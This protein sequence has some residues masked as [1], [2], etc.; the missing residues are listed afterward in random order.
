[1]VRGMY[2]GDLARRWPGL[3]S[4]FSGLHRCEVVSRVARSTTRKMSWGRDI[5]L[6]Q[7]H[8]WPAIIFRNE[9]FERAPRDQLGRNCADQVE[10]VCQMAHAGGAFSRGDRVAALTAERIPEAVI[11]MLGTAAHRRESGASCSPDFGD[12]AIV[13]PVRPD[14]T[15][16]VLVTCGQGRPTYG[17]DNCLA[18]E[19]PQALNFR[20]CRSVEVRGGCRRI[21]SRRVS[22]L[23]HHLRFARSTLCVFR[24]D[25]CP[26][27][28]SRKHCLNSLNCRS[29]TRW[30]SSIPPA[31]QDRAE[32]HRSRRGRDA[33]AAS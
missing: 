1:M 10:G 6:A 28:R 32:V 11:A 8:N 5:D 24:V 7:R 20:G 30:P 13:R 4:G 15:P 14:R 31:R 26:C 22:R 2:I 27:L 16:E 18:G 19:S 21:R 17:K 33:T 3:R 12:D 23:H 9:N 25:R 29:I